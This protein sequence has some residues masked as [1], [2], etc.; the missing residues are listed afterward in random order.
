MILLDA[1]P[2]DEIRNTRRIHAVVIDGR[3]Y[4]AAAVERIKRHVESRARSWTVSAKIL[5]RFLRNPVSY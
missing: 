3:L 1:N 5:W 2:L 4:D